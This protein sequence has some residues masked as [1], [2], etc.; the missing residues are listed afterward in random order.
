[1][2]VVE[3]SSWFV[4]GMVDE[5]YGV[6]GGALGGV[7]KGAGLVVGGRRSVGGWTWRVEW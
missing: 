7:R 4:C 6:A 3:F 1:M 2:E 5:G